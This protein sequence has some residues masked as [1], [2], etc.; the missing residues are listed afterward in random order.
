M[1]Y[2]DLML[3]IAYLAA[4]GFLLMARLAKTGFDNLS[5]PSAMSSRV[6]ADAGGKMTRRGVSF[7]EELRVVLNSQFLLELLQSLY[8]IM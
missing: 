5:E 3:L 8:Y 1:C 7:V 2:C 6:N 4:F